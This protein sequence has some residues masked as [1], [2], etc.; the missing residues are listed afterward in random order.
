MTAPVGI[1]SISD[2]PRITVSELIGNPLFVP[3]KLQELMANQFISEALFRNAGANPSGVVAY[4]EGNPS[5]LQDD[6]ADVAEFGEI[7]VSLGYRGLPRTAFAVKRALGVRV[8][9]EMID[10][11]RIGA[12]ED[13]MRQLRN[14][15]VRANDRA[16]KALLQS[17]VVPTTAVS[18]AWTN[19]ASNPR[20]DIANAMAAIQSAQPTTFPAGIGSTDEYYGFMPDTIVLHPSLFSTLIGNDNFMK[21]YYNSPLTP[22]APSFTGT[23]PGN[24][25]GLNVVE[26]RSFPLNSVL[27]LERG[28]VGFYSD[29][30]PL[31]FTALYPEGNGPNGGPTESYRSDA[32]HK[33]A[34]A[35]DQPKAAMWLTGVA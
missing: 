1:V 25:L 15:F 12:V 32:S 18:T 19:S 34:L 6:V 14:T 29:T 20:I 31:Q 26:S 11:N 24:I 17:S 33:R 27:I 10:E 16:V 21:L 35:V 5:F 22:Q 13:Q 8:S 2:G 9:K 3:T 7:P 30:R 23:L 4:T 28:T